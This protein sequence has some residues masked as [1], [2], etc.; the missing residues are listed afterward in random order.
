MLTQRTITEREENIEHRTSNIERPMALHWRRP[1]M[2]GVRCS[3]FDVSHLSPVLFF[4][5]AVVTRNFSANGAELTKAQTDFFET[6][7]RP[8]LTENCYKC[9]SPANGKVKGGLELD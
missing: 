2:F 5:L 6:K 7:V 9:H 8:I 3:M 1:S 4:L